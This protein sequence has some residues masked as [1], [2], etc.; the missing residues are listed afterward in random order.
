MIIKINYKKSINYKSMLN[1]A[2]FINDN[3]NIQDLESFFTTSEINSIKEILKNSDLSK[4]ITSLNL[5]SKK[6]V[7]ILNLKKNIDN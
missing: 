6:S 7:L 2:V 5:N 3:D 4:N 1:Y